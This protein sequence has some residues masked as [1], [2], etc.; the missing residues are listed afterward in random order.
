MKY[1]CKKNKILSFKT[2]FLLKQNLYNPWALSPEPKQGF[3][4]DPLE[5][6]GGPQTP[7]LKQVGHLF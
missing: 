6:L 4:L 3:A 5:A 1:Q 7:C 2:S